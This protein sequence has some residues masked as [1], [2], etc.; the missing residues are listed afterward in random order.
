V[1]KF[2]CL[3]ANANDR[4]Q[5]LVHRTAFVD[6][7][8]IIITIA[9]ARLILCYAIST[10]CFGRLW[11]EG[12]I[13]EGVQAPITS[14]VLLPGVSNWPSPTYLIARFAPLANLPAS[15]RQTASRLRGSANTLQLASGGDFTVRRLDT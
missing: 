4:D 11:D 2:R 15:S 9:F 3:K 14:S 5:K 12:K 8:A 6:A 13:I 1:T 10:V 7:R